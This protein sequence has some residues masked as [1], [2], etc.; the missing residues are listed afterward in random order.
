MDVAWLAHCARRGLYQR[1]YS[2]ASRLAGM[3]DQLYSAEAT[4]PHRHLLRSGYHSKYDK[5]YPQDAFLKR[6]P[7]S[8][9]AVW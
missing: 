4:V 5:N 8:Q 3:V 2:A 1:M 9:T 7:P 6:S